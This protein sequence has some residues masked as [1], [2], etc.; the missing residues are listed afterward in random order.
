[1]GAY[2][3]GGANGYYGGAT[4][5]LPAEDGLVNRGG[6]GGGGGDSGSTSGGSGI[7]ILRWD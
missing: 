1:M 3:F 6:G 2:N 5:A 4:P 7:V